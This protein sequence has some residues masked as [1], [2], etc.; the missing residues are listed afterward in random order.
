MTDPKVDGSSSGSAMSRGP[1]N[2]AVIIE[3]DG[4]QAWA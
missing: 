3:I 1:R 4:P 2:G